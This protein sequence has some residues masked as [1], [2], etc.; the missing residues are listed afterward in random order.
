MYVVLGI[1]CQALCLQDKGFSVELSPFSCSANVDILYGGLKEN[2]SQR[3]G[4]IV[5]VHMVFLEEAC[6]CGGG[7]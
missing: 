3:G 7:L 5:G 1:K 2:S 4:T 6:Y